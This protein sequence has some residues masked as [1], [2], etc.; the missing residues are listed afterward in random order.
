MQPLAA[1]HCL[2]AHVKTSLN[3]NLN[4]DYA[5]DYYYFLRVIPIVFMT[6]TVIVTVIIVIVVIIIIP[7]III[8]LNMT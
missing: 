8:V 6:V 7:F 4:A 5:S 3:H 2:A 1:Q